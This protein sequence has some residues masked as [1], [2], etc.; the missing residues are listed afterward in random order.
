MPTYKESD[1]ENTVVSLLKDL[2]WKH[3][4]APDL[5]DHFD[6]SNPLLMDDLHT[7]LTRINKNLPGEAVQEA[8]TKVSDPE[9][10]GFLQKNVTFT[11]YFQN[12]IPVRCYV[13]DKEENCLVR[14]VD[15]DNADANIFKVV[16]QLTVVGREKKR[17]DVL[18]YI[19]GFPVVVMELKNPAKEDAT[20]ENAYRQLRN[21][22]KSIPALFYYNQVCVISDMIQNKAGTITSPEDRFMD[23]K[24]KD[25]TYSD[26]SWLDY[27][28]FYEGLFDHR[29]FLDILQNFILYESGEEPVKILA[30]YHQYF[31]VTEA[32]KRAERAVKTD[33]RGGVFWHTQ[34][35]GKSLSMVFYA[36]LLQ[37]TLNSPTIVVM[38]DRINLDNQLYGLF[39]KCEKF[40]RQRP[41]QAES[42]ENLVKLLQDRQ[43]N[44]IVF[45]T[46]F[47]FEEGNRPLSKR[48]NIVVMCDEAHR[49]Q[50]GFEYKTEIISN[51]GRNA[52]SVNKKLGIAQ[53]IREALPNATFIGFT[54]TPLSVKDRNTRAV[55]G[56]YVDV[57]DMTQSVADKATLPVYYESR[58][59]KLN[60]NQKTLN[61]IDTE[62]ERLA[63]QS[64]PESIERS[65][66]ML[67]QMES[68]LGN[69]ETIDSLC[70]DIISHYENNREDLLSGKALV[71]AY[72]RP[73]AIK[74]YKRLLELRPAW[75]E[76]V[77]VVMTGT[78]ND[79]EEWKE[80]IGTNEHKR[81]LEK[82]FKDDDSP[83]K[84]AIVV[85]MWLTGFDVPS[86]STMYVYKPMKG[87]NLMQAIA[88][89]N[90]VYPGKEGGLIVDYVGIAS[91]LKEAMNEYTHRDKERFG[92][93]DIA[94]TAYYKFQTQLSICQSFMERFDY[95]SFFSDDPRKRTDAYNSGLNYLLAPAREEKRK[96]F[97]EEAYKLKQSLSLCSSIVSKHDREEAA[98]FEALRSGMQK[99]LKTGSGDSVLSLRDINKQISELL[100]ESIK[101]E[102]VESFL[103]EK[104]SGN[105]FSLFDPEF[106]NQIAAMKQKNIAAEMLRRLMNDQVR[107]YQHTNKVQAVKFSEKMEK[108][109]KSY[110]NGHLTNEE[111]IKELLEMA[112]EIKSM[113]QQG[114]ALG[115]T[116]E[117]KAFYDALTKPRALKDFYK[118]DELVK[119]THELTTMLRKN[120]TIDW[121]RKESARANMRRMVKRLLK[122]YKYPPEGFDEAIGAVIDQCEMWADNSD[123]QWQD[124]QNS[125]REKTVPDAD[126]LIFQRSGNGSSYHNKNSDGS[127]AAEDNSPYRE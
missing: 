15:F 19:N 37:K 24:S 17:P 106:L 6:L 124:S 98:Y 112:E 110:Y 71:V 45:T 120:R 18:L 44:G 21:Y 118:N 77:N 47:K 42:K 48:S 26:S 88:R 93:M 12:G 62:Y 111:V 34:G 92:D 54:G 63:N 104:A 99:I 38:T 11:D 86:L 72:S 127:I 13:K 43:A 59:I 64:N 82:S 109:M 58:V 30:G 83:F 53:L 75:K 51:D 14:L 52:V 32:I 122:K 61:Q 69:Q 74:I 85:D 40:L 121:Q 73:I 10:I 107:L 55:F 100:K 105:E 33:H 95:S 101:S 119:L 125:K 2:G 108:L 113:Q 46:M 80:I 79:P 27:S 22:M 36:H 78:N 94:N 60:L 126:V 103:Q 9:G 50:Y 89:V 90:R 115:L 39:C 56:D 3:L 91:A 4:Y 35:S 23:W 1:F 25:G 5:K 65:K 114:Q 57:Y 76:K 28:I 96:S 84:I 49:G 8:I 41:V 16:N 20:T 31:A 29:R 102:G 81:E 87:A 70:E 116:P 123:Y 66:R 117:E 67:G 97:L 7:G 68:I